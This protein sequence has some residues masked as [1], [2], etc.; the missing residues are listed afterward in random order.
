MISEL[1]SKLEN[2]SNLSYD[3]MKYAMSGILRGETT[4]QQTIEFLSHLREKQM[5]SF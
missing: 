1:I 3:E 2:K 5:M 4:E